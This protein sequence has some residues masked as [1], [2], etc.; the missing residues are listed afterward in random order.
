MFEAGERREGAE[1]RDAVLREHQRCQA[2]DGLGYGGLDCGDAVA[3]EEERAEL[4]AEGEVAQRCD[5]IVGEVD[6]F[7]ILRVGNT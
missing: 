4:W 5:V 3:R 1:L 6:A 7:L 2:R